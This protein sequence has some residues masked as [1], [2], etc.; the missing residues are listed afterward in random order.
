MPLLTEFAGV[1]LSSFGFTRGGAAAG[2][3]ELISSTVL[4]STTASVTFSSIPNT[5]KHL[6]VRMAARIA[7]ATGTNGVEFDLRLNSDSGANYASHRLY[8]DGTSVTST[9]ASAQNQMAVL[10]GLPSASQ[11]AGIFGAAV[12]DILD[13]ASTTKNKTLRTLNGYNGVSNR[14]SMHSGLWVST[15]AVNSILVY[16]INAF[17]FASGSRFSLYGIKGA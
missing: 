13:Y 8:G 7:T 9:A 12:I 3:Y 17:S 6:Q 14:I 16:D 4:G 11:T 5:Y 10:Q 1:G 2:A 15:A